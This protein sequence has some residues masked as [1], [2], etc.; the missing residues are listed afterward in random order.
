MPVN[1]IFQDK[2][3]CVQGLRSKEPEG[4]PIT[5]YIEATRLQQGGREQPGNGSICVSGECLPFPLLETI[6]T[7]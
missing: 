7:S 6:L 4:K 2:E 1:S 5:D 3:K